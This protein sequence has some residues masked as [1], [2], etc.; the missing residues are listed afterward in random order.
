MY[1]ESGV[2]PL[3]AHTPARMAAVFCFYRSCTY[4]CPQFCVVFDVAH[5]SVDGVHAHTSTYVSCV[6]FPVDKLIY[7]FMFCLNFIPA[8][9]CGGQ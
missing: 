2:P 1:A 3:P 9:T 7:F 4:V 6:I 8:Q 5:K